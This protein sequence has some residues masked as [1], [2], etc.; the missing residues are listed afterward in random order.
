MRN[1]LG[2]VSMSVA[3]FAGWTWSAELVWTGAAD[4]KWETGLNWTNKAGAA[5]VF[6]SGDDVLFDDGAAART[7]TLGTPAVAGSVVFD[8]GQAFTFAV[9]SGGKLTQAASFVKRGSGT[10]TLQGAICHTYTNDIRIEAGTLF[11]LS[12]NASATAS[13]LGNASV[14]R[15]I[16][17]ASNAVLRL[18]ERNTFG[19]AQETAL[20][21]EISVEPGGLLELGYPGVA[22]KGVNTLGALT[23]NDAALAYTNLMGS[24]IYGF[25]KVCQTFRLLGT[26][27]YNFTNYNDNG[28]LMLLNSEPHTAF[29]VADI[30]GDDGADATFGFPFKEYAG[31][32]GGL[33]KT[34]AGNLA[35]TDTGSTFTGDI[36]VRE[37]TLTASGNLLTFGASS[38]LGNLRVARTLTV[39]TNAALVF[40]TRNVLGAAETPPPLLAVTVDHGSLSL[41]DGHTLFGDLTLDGGALSYAN[42]HGDAFGVMRFSR[43][44]LKGATPFLFDVPAGATHCFFNLD[45][46]ALSVIEVADITGNDETDA[47]F[48]IPFRNFT[49]NSA[50]KPGGFTKTGPGTLKLDSSA[51]SFSGDI[52]IQEGT[53]LQDMV[54][55]GTNPSTSPLGNPLAERRVT[56]STNAMLIL[57]QRNS[58]SGAVPTNTLAAEIRVTGGTLKLG[59]AGAVT[60]VNT[61]GALTLDGGTL[62]YADMCGPPYGFLK[63]CRRFTLTGTAPHAFPDT[64][65]AGCYMTLNMGHTT[66]IDVTDITGDAVPDATFGFA[67][68]NHASSAAY[69]CGLIKD[70]AGTLRLT[71]ASAYTGGTLVSNGI[72]RVD[73]S[74][75]ASSGVT[76]SANGFLGGTGTV[77]NVTV[78]L[79]GGFAAPAGQTQPLVVTGALALEGGGTVRIDNPDGLPSDQIRVTLAQTGGTVAGAENLSSWVVE[80]EGVPASVNHRVQLRG[81]LLIAGFSPH[82]TVLSVR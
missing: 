69:P 15:T 51:S 14:E 43:L 34:G 78:Q 57:R 17:V 76:V 30:T 44:A 27:P 60:G 63:V 24:T 48:T 47:T 73:G 12:A 52:V 26:R 62:D 68:N 74:I 81:N 1:G 16:S 9:G 29:E 36:D 65:A 50:E 72:L 18:G 79:G 80:I 19:G 5:S 82:G 38:A 22:N 41:A 10:L 56:V 7:V 46:N 55:G 11:T 61:V 4:G 3:V 54:R 42:G 6:A 32:P 13:P 77:K 39:R 49:G 25:L 75:A 67:F 8:H 37:G 31:K 40:A 58:L 59:G 20:K 64:G 21:A 45:T 23:L 2:L 28:C 70:G 33:V 66:V 35:L 53:V 71:A